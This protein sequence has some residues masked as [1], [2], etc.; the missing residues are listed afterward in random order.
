MILQPMGVPGKC[1]AHVRAWTPDEDELLMSLYAT[2][3]PE[4]I[5]VRVNRTRHAVYARASLLRQHYPERLAYKATPFSPQEDA[6]IRKC[7]RTM[8][9]LQMG[10]HLGRHRDSIRYRARVLGADLTKCGDLLS[11]TKVPDDDVRLIRALRDDPHPR[12]LTFR[13][14]GEKFGISGA[15]ARNVYVFRRTAEDAVLRRLLP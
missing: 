3:T 9:A 10:L 7:A 12:R 2:T 5:A 11:C 6:F 8:T 15:M 1:P 4:E 13:E 14:I